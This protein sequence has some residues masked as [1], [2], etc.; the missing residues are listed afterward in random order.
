MAPTPSGHGYWLVATDGGVFSFGDAAFHGSTGGLRLNRPIV[1]MARTPSGHGYWLVASDGGIFSFGDADFHGSTGAIRLNQPIVGMAATPSGHG[2][3]LVAPDG[4]IFGFGDA[5]FHGSMGGANLGSKSVIGMATTA[6][7]RGYWLVATRPSMPGPPSGWTPRV[8]ETWQYQLQG[9]I[10]T[11]V[12]A[13]VFDIDGFDTPSSV[14]ATLHGHGAHV[15]CYVSAGAW[16]NWRPD[17]G[18]FPSSVLGSGNGWPGEKWLDIRQLAILRPIMAAR[19]DICKAKGFDAVE[20]DNVDGYANSTGFPLTG[21]QQIAYN[22]MLA[23]LAHERGLRVGLKNDLDQVGFAGRL[24]RLRG[25][26]AVLPIFGMRH[27][28]SVHRGGEAGVQRRVQRCNRYLLSESRR[29]EALVDLQAPVAHRIS[30]RLLAH[31]SVPNSLRTV[32]RGSAWV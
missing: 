14:V 16:E 22:K 18:R 28:G 30:H 31:S 3:W 32:V 1:G 2:Y 29:A 20:P 26:R 25:Q 23:G 24:V 13:A 19:F 7:G 6:S 5:G 11:S 8:G 27:P 10:D 4:G 9:A 15:V 12:S 17:A 21:A